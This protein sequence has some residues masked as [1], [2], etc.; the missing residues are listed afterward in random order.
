MTQPHVVPGPV[1]DWRTVPTH[2]A[3]VPAPTSVIVAYDADGYAWTDEEV[4]RFWRRTARTTMR[5]AFVEHGHTPEVAD[6]V[7]VRM[8]RALIG[9]H[10]DPASDAWRAHSTYKAPAHEAPV[11]PSPPVPFFELAWQGATEGFLQ[12][13]HHP[14][15]LLDPDE[16]E[17]PT[18]AA[19]QANVARAR[20]ARALYTDSLTRP[21]GT[22][23]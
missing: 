12:A 17:A 13:W 5:A 16:D 6:D 9:Y 23:A 3:G 2:P 1:D 11:P 10:G 4:R 7:A 21:K 15:E 20:H 22:A 19:Q 8:E 14:R 18:M